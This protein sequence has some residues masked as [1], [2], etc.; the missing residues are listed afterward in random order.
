MEN[1]IEEFQAHYSTIVIR[2]LSLCPIKFF[3]APKLPFFY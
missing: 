1:A 2:I 3:L